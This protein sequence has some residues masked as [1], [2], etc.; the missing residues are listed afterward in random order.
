MEIKGKNY[1]NSTRKVWDN[2]QMVNGVSRNIKLE[3]DANYQK[4][5]VLWFKGQN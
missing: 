5:F 3:T 1:R 2:L 4:R